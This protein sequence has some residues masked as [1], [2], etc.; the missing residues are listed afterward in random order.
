MKSLQRPFTCVTRI[1]IDHFLW[2]ISSE[3][4]L[5]KIKFRHMF[6]ISSLIA[7]CHSF[8]KHLTL[9]CALLL[10]PA[11]VFCQSDCTEAVEICE[12]KD[13]YFPE[14]SGY[15]DQENLSLTDSK[16]KETN[17]L[18]L[19]L[20]VEA[21][22]ELEFVIVPD[23]STDDIDF[24]LFEGSGC[25]DKATMRIMTSGVTI[26]QEESSR[27]ISHMGLQKTS[28]DEKESDGCNEWDDN[29]LKPALL[30]KGK[31]YHL[32]VNN[33]NSE[34]G[35]TILFSGDE[36]LELV[37][38]CNKSESEE[39]DISLY[40]NPASDLLQISLNKAVE[41]GYQ[42]ELFDQ[43]GKLHQQNIYNQ[44]NTQFD[45]SISDLSPGKYYLRV[46][47]SDEIKLKSFIKI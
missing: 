47:S 46:K 36:T 9:L 26:G 21:S 42:M 30:K 19:K 17:S 10:I 12:L 14:F 1:L 7:A 23:S 18:W 6:R 3:K 15:G 8:R 35:F 22:G 16:L 44:S 34:N 37:N 40:P 25:K 38:T 11:S 27:C 41:N 45:L 24:V 2:S 43:A 33:F 5:S 39:L 28:A 4:F 20:N 32:L 29:Y 31:T 13:Y